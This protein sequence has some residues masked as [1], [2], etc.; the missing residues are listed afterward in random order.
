MKMATTKAVDKM[1][2][3]KPSREDLREKIIQLI[4]GESDREKVSEWAFSI[5]D[6]DHTYVDDQ[7]TWK[8]LQCLGAIDLP[9]IDRDFLYGKEDFESWLEELN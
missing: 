3:K 8:I 4:S 5:I 6:D 7:V 9:D 1:T 2:E